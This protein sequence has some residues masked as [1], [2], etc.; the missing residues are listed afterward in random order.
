[1][2]YHLEFSI[3]NLACICHNFQDSIVYFNSDIV[4]QPM[5][6]NGYNSNFNSISLIHILLELFFINFKGQPFY[7]SGKSHRRSMNRLPCQHTRKQIISS[8]SQYSFLLFPFFTILCNS[9]DFKTNSIV[10][11]KTPY[12][13]GI[14]NDGHTQLL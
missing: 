5:M 9:V 3:L 8:P 10:V 12:K 7:S 1:M 4:S 11:I 13:S 6:I 2:A 14:Q